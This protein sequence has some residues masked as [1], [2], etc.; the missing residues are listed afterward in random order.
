MRCTNT[1]C[2]SL[3]LI[4]ATLPPIPALAQFGGGL[5]D[6]GQNQFGEAGPSRNG[7]GGILA[8]LGSGQVTDTPTSPDAR[9]EERLEPLSPTVSSETSPAV[10]PDSGSAQE[11]VAWIRSTAFEE[12]RKEPE[13]TITSPEEFLEFVRSNIAIGTYPGVLKGARGLLSERAGNPLEIALVGAALLEEAGHFVRIGSREL[14]D[15]EVS[16]AIDVAAEHNGRRAEPQCA[17]FNQ[18]PGLSTWSEK[19]C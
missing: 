1:W 19:R 10:S 8:P 17:A 2:P 18:L 9:Q 6:G 16:Q 14:S 4:H 13:Q 12:Q 5:F 7:F 11:M 3:A 15:E